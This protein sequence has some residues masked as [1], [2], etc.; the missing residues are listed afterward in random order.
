M[1]AHATDL[2]MQ[3]SQDA[4]PPIEARMVEIVF[5]NHANHLGTLFGGQALAWMD[6]AAFLAAT[7]YARRT[8]VTAR[9]DQVDFKLPIRVGQMVETV[10]RVIDVGRSSMQVEV[11]LI[12]EDLLTGDRRLCTRGRFTMIALDGDGRPV[13]VPAL[14]NQAD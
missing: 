4:V 13:A 1:P 11:E 3:S 7:R 10:A 5:P 9:S 14:E 6:K 12:A 2:H 8:V